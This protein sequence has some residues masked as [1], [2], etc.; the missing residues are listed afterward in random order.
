[1]RILM[2]IEALYRVNREMYKDIDAAKILGT[3]ED[4][5]AENMQDRGER[6]AFG[7]A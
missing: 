2:L 1:M 3:D 7:S 4:K 5:I 6:R